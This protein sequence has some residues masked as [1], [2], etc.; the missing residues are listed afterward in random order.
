M[1]ETI[2]GCRV[3]KFLVGFAVACLVDPVTNMVVYLSE[4]AKSAISVKIA[5]NNAKIQSLAPEESEEEKIH[6]NVIGF[7]I[8]NDEEEGDY[9]DEE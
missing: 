5:Q 9:Q 8:P 6:T 1:K 2:G 4:W 7:T 3:K